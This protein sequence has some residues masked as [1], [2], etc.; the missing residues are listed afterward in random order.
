MGYI[1]ESLFGIELWE[2][3]N[4]N[5][6]KRIGWEVLETV[7]AANLSRNFNAYKKE[8]RNGVVRISKEWFYEN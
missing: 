4:W 2:K 7:N 1:D 8:K 3:L 5:E 6:S